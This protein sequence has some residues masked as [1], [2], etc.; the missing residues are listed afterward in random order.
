MPSEIYHS[1]SPYI[2][3]GWMLFIFDRPAQALAL[4]SNYT[5]PTQELTLMTSHA[6]RSV[7]RYALIKLKQQANS[8]YE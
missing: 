6:S 7:Y 5:T 8:E 1:T 2:A 4:H 3:S